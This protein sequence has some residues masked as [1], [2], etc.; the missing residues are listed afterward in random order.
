MPLTF[1][2]AIWNAMLDAIEPVIGSGGQLLLRSGAAP[3]TLA[4]AST[5]TVIATINLPADFMSNA[6]GGTKAL[7]GTWTDTAADAAGTVGHFEFRSSGGTPHL[8]GS[9]TGQGGGG[10]IELQNVAI[11]AG[12]SVTITAFNLNKPA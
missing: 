3:A 6:S 4:A 1:S 9:V 11:N 2:D 10:D 12:Q 7:L 8:R 5:G